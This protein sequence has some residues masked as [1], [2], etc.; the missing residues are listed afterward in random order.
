M[1]W[2][3]ILAILLIV[4]ALIVTRFRSQIKMAIYVWRMFR[5]MRQVG[6]GKEERRIE[7]EAKPHDGALVRCARCGT[8]TEQ[9]KALSLRSGA[10]FCSKNCMETA[11][12]VN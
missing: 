12:I 1:K 9:N 5:K 11:A 6:N 7:K 2:L 4:L 3:I 10:V 8:W